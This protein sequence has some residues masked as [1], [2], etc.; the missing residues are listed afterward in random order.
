MYK[1]NLSSVK[2]SDLV[3]IHLREQ[4]HFIDSFLGPISR[5]SQIP[6][7]LRAGLQEL[8]DS[9]ACCRELSVL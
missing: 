8:L 9:V 4:F 6:C 3:C 1:K 5:D 7:E 2:A